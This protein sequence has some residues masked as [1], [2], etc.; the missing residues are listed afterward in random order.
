MRCVNSQVIFTLTD[1]WLYPWAYQLEKTYSIKR[2]IWTSFYSKTACNYSLLFLKVQYFILYLGW[3]YNK[4][5]WCFFFF[6]LLHSH[7][8]L[9]FSAC[10]FPLA[11]L[12]K[13][14][15]GCSLFIQGKWADWISSNSASHIHIFQTFIP[16]LKGAKYNISL[17]LHQWCFRIAQK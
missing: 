11:C 9:D 17:Q 3:L 14:S 7:F 8:F 12:K 4:D 2:L 16:G 6:F 10:K 1:T 13:C 15:K 5:R